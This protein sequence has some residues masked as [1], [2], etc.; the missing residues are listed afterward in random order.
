MCTAGRCFEVHLLRT[1]ERKH[2][3][4]ELRR[5][6]RV[7]VPCRGECYGVPRNNHERFSSRMCGARPFPCRGKHGVVPLECTECYSVFD[8]KPTFENGACLSLDETCQPAAEIPALEASPP[9]PSPPGA[10]QTALPDI[11]QTDPSNPLLLCV[12]TFCCVSARGVFRVLTL[13]WSGLD[14]RD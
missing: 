8:G 1:K 13:S 6:G 11:A 2:R 5:F 7:C 9:L 10:R 3:K 14:G 4:R 12:E